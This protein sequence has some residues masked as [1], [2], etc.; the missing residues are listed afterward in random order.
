MK[1]VA[2]NL[3]QT[4][5]VSRHESFTSEHVIRRLPVVTDDEVLLPLTHPEPSTTGDRHG[6]EHGRVGVRARTQSVVRLSKRVLNRDAALYPPVALAKPQTRATCQPETRDCP[7][8]GTDVVMAIIKAQITCPHCRNAVVYRA[9]PGREYGMWIKPEDATTDKPD[10]DGLAHCRPCLRVSCKY[11]LYLD[12]N[13]AT[14]SIKTNFPHL[15]PEE[16]RDSCTLDVADQMGITLEDVGE[17]LNLTRERIRQL[18]T[19]GM[20][21]LKVNIRDVAPGIHEFIDHELVHESPLALAQ[22]IAIG[23]SH[24]VSDSGADEIGD[25]RG[26]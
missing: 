4:D 21:K 22:D 12:I 16:M 7:H 18:E 13:R 25:S 9:L 8:C 15:E 20:D 6:R 23:Y 2:H 10:T 3:V 14:G 1:T 17:I 19:R 11:N 5:D 26:T 24:S